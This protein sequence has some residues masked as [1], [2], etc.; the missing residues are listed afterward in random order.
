MR[1]HSHVSEASATIRRDVI[2]GFVTL[3]DDEVN[4]EEESQRVELRED[5]FDADKQA[6][7]GEI[8]TRKI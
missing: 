8:K 5:S 3:R 1:T 7:A 2:V 6:E 4:E